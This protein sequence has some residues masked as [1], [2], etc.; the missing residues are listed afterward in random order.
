VNLL[1]HHLTAHLHHLES[2]A[3]QVLSRRV[4]HSIMRLLHQAGIR[5][6]IRSRVIHLLFLDHQSSLRARL[7]VSLLLFL[8]VPVGLEVLEVLEAQADQVDLETRLDLLTPT[9]EFLFFRSELSTALSNHSLT[10]TV[11]AQ[12]SPPLLSPTSRLLSSA[13]RTPSRRSRH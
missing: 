12:S 13:T 7:V 8:V 2:L 11:Q 10:N 5:S 4:F 1:H 6:Q 9:G 3:I